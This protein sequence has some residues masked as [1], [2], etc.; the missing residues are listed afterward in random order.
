MAMVKCAWCGGS[1]TDGPGGSPCGVC[2]GD[3]HINVPEPPTRCGRC[4]GTGRVR[5]DVTEEVSSC[6][7]C[8][9]SGWSS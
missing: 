3:G 9:G 7:G 2:G 1:G 8:G 4:N 6:S 5:N